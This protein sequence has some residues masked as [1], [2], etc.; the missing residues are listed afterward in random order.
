MP[1]LSSFV[2]SN[3]CAMFSFGWSNA[4]FACC[5]VMLCLY[6]QQLLCRRNSSDTISLLNCVCTVLITLLLVNL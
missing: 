5:Y 2:M 6:L 1:F 3:G 4:L